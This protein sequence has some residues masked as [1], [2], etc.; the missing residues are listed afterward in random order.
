[1]A[2]ARSGSEL[3]RWSNLSAIRRVLSARMPE[4]ADRPVG[5]T[6]IAELCRRHALARPGRDWATRRD[7]ILTIGCEWDLLNDSLEAQA[8]SCLDFL[9]EYLLD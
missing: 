7:Q 6:Q 1:M 2:I 3:R 5:L 9:A 8:D 4:F